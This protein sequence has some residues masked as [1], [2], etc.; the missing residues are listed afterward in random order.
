MDEQL[1]IIEVNTSNIKE[2][3]ICCALSN[4]KNLKGVEAKK[5]WLSE[6]F[7]EGLRFYKL[8]VR[9][10]VFIEYLPAEFA[11]R[12]VHAPGY[13]FIHCLW[14]SGQ[15]KNKGWGKKLLAKCITDAKNTNGVAVVTSKKPFL[16][17]KK[18][19]LKNGF[20]QTDTADPHFE[21]MTL[22]LN[23]NAPNPV[24]YPTA[25][26]ATCSIKKGMVI[27]YSSQC[28]FTELYVNEMLEAA[29][30]AGHDTKKIKIDSCKKAQQMT[31]AFGVFNVFLN[32]Q[33][34]AHQI[35]SKKQT[36]SLLQKLT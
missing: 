11:W 30:E 36:T 9:G 15:Y 25:K 26:E 17:D 31:T 28:P 20:K 4:K 2:E 7:V 32:G 6:R 1:Q 3:H 24:F 19:F 18:F 13:L 35:F 27:Y 21:L 16:T 8:N 29:A 22:K 10:K 33:F 34:F 14:V 5:N 23:S 12:P